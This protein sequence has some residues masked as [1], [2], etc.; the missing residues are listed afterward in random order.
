MIKSKTKFRAT[1]E[2]IVRIF[3]ANNM[4]PIITVETLGNGEFNAVFKVCTED[5]KE[6]AVKI[7]PSHDSKVL[8]YENNMMKSEV[9]WYEQMREKI[10]ISIP[11]VYVSDF[12]ENI[13]STSYFIMEKMDGKPL[14]E[15]GFTDAEYAK[16]QEQ[17]IF[18]LTQIH[19]IHNDM[20]GYIQTGLQ[21]SWYA[22]IRGMVSNLIKDCETMGKETPNGH[23]FLM[24]ID[25]HEDLL[26]DCECC[27]VNF[28][29]WDSNVLYHNGKLCWIDPERSFWGDR[30]ADFITLGKG[31]KSPLSEKLAEIEIY[32]RT[33][34]KPIIYDKNMEIRYQ[35]AVGYLALIEEVEKYV[36]YEPEEENYIR[37][38]V[39]AKAMFEMVFN[40]L[41]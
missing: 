40:I 38:T 2:D 24:A 9:F 26:R 22:A 30:I 27:M 31:Q 16:V 15:M 5:N 29:L 14:W 20:F 18:M 12:S 25:R 10:D 19:Q 8:T 13:I 3:R 41:F 4:S 7:A 39:D 28:D 34:E 32:N 6:Y 23:K 1:E 36:R 21:N 35:V 37:N 11:K 17:K 33:S